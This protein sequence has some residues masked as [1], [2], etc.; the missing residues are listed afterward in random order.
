MLGDNIG[1]TPNACITQN[2]IAI[3]TF[4]VYYKIT[5]HHVSKAQ[6]KGA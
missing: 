1:L 4:G 6:M 5:N 2:C 3:P